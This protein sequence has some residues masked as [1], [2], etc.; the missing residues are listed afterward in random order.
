[1]GSAVCS[2]PV[3]ANGTLYI[4]NTSQL[5]AITAAAGERRP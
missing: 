3:P 1:M 5:F 2:T 4:M